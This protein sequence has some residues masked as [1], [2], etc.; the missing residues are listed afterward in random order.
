MNDTVCYFGGLDWAT[1]H[2]DVV[3]VNN[4]GKVAA[5]LRFD[6]TQEGWAK[7]LELAQ[8]YAG[9]KIAIETSRGLAIKQMLDHQIP[10]YPINP[11]SSKAF[12]QRKV[13]SGNKTD[14]LD[15]YSLAEALRVDGH[16][17]KEFQP[18]DPLTEELRLLCRDEVALIEQRTLLVN[19]LIAAL[20]EYYPTALES[21]D[22]WTKP[23]AWKFL[24][25]FP[26]PKHL[27]DAGECKWQNFLHCH[28]LWRPD[29]KEARLNSF[30]KAVNFQGSEATIKAKS[31]LAL[32]I[33]SLL[34]TLED[35]LKEYRKE[36]EKL[37][38]KH[39]DHDVFGS[40]PG[41][42]EKLAPRI[43]SEIGSNR[44]QFKDPDAL[45]VYAGT[46]PVCYQS[47]QIHKVYMRRACDKHLR[48]ALHLFADLSRT[49]EAWAGV[50]YKGLREKGKSHACALRSL[51]HRWLK[52][53]WSMWQKRTT[54]DSNTHLLN[55]LKHGSWAYELTKTKLADAKCE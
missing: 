9:L 16:H 46:A 28:K 51:A 18:Q 4:E 17:W 1:D 36:I 29:T 35:R 52:I 34:L 45:R 49:R 23:A 42:G 5:Q 7:F 15:A 25:R 19:Q 3:I 48:A 20:K 11:Q 38:E 37:F 13:S 2:H 40:L 30:A 47:G 21:F 31:R 41:A 33:V 26:T 44:D 6:H 8:K 32:S 14:Y 53:I 50:Y 43:L 10:V 22:N 27:A 12:R 24:Q 55:Q 39:P 54:Y